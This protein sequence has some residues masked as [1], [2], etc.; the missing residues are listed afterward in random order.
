MRNT[1]YVEWG[2]MFTPVAYVAKHGTLI[3][4]ED[5]AAASEMR[6]LVR[7]FGQ[8][9]MNDLGAMVPADVKRRE[10]VEVRTLEEIEDAEFNEKQAMEV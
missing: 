8:R 6:L 4:V 10:S 3:V 5:S 2:P 7:T 9:V 1:I